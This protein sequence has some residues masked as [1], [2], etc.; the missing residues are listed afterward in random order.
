MNRAI[1]LARSYG[2]A[3]RFADLGDWGVD[4]L[5]SEYDPSVPE[6]RLNVRI[7]EQLAP[8]ELGDFVSLAIGHELYHHRE[9]VGEIAV[10]GDRVAREH[11]ANDHARKLLET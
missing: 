10:I 5:R 4:E 7:A 6:I 11:A 3:I 8:Q 1:A 9:R 2:V